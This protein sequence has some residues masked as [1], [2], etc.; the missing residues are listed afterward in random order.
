[1]GQ[2]ARQALSEQEKSTGR[3]LGKG[4]AVI[5]GENPCGEAVTA[6]VWNQHVLLGW[7][8]GSGPC[9]AHVQILSSGKLACPL[10]RLPETAPW[11]E[12]MWTE[13]TAQGK[14]ATSLPSS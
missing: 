7:A 8:E 13:G 2:G 14:Y 5:R 4:V 1:M 6:G 10:N 3:V 9:T 12:G 11:T